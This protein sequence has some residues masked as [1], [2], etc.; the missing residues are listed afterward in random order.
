MSQPYPVEHWLGDAEGSAIGYAGY[1]NDAEAERG[2][3]FDVR[4][5]DYG[6]LERY[7]G[8][9]GLT[10]DLR[11]CLE[12]LGRPVAGTVLDVAAGT[13]WAVPILLEAGASKVYC[14]E[15]SRHRLLDIGPLV[16]DHYGVARE[17]V[18]LAYGSFYDL[19]LQPGSCSLAFLSQAFHHADDPHALLAQLAR[20]LEP[21][22]VVVIVGEHVISSRDVALYAA[23][24]VLSVLPSGLQRRLM[25]E[26]LAGRPRLRPDGAQLV[27]VDPLMGD[28]VYTA[29]EY[30]ELF[31]SAGFRHRKLR[32]S[33]SPYQSFVLER[34]A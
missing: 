28:H 18:V 22:G 24:A 23:K 34:V 19:H 30:R 7:L 21:G 17:R 6:A 26:P 11:H 2:K 3:P 16:L 31:R 14:V 33:G 15:Y 4:D 20:V 1:W 13:L 25:K 29:R 10:G 9:V 12:E 8:E 5:G 27:P 32:R